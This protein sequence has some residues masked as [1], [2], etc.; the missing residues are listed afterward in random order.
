MCGLDGFSTQNAHGCPDGSGDGGRYGTSVFSRILRYGIQVFKTN[1][2]EKQER[3]G[4][5]FD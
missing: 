5:S 2:N 1:R 4:V 3:G